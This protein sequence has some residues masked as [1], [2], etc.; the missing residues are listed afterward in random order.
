M[1]DT[2]FSPAPSSKSSAA[3]TTGSDANRQRFAHIPGWGADLDRGMRPA[4][5][6]E[7]TP[8]RLPHAVG[9]PAQQQTE[10]EIL[11]STERA[12]IT[13]IYG[14]PQPPKGLSGMVRRVA[15]RYSE[16][17]LRHWLMLL[18]ADRIH[19]GEGLLEDL[20]HGHLPNLYA[21]MGGPAAL[22]HNPRAVAK[23]AAVG[24]GLAVLLVYLSRRN[25]RRR[26]RY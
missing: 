7:R 18:M 14:T 21:E 2:T 16:N 6:M 26:D 9:Q 8:P 24:V 17:D 3:D 19:C 1:E 22:R 20:A 25:R 11:H 5:P 12:G 13:P 4:V 23:Q 10:V 15:F